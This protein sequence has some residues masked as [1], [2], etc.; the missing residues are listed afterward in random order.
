MKRRLA[1]PI[2]TML[3]ACLLGSSGLAHGGILPPV[4]PGNG[5]GGYTGPT[6]PGPPGGGSGSPGA[7]APPGPATGGPS[8]NPTG[9]QPPSTGGASRGPGS[10][11]TGG[12]DSQGLDSWE[13]WWHFNKDPY[14][15]L[16]RAVARTTFTSGGADVIPSSSTTAIPSR[17]LVRQRIVPA[18]AHLLESERANDITTGALVAL[19][20]IGEPADLP[21]ESSAIPRLV[22][23]LADA[24]Q[25][26]AE[27]AALAL[28]ISRSEAAIPPLTD[29]LAA[30]ARGAKLVG[31]K[32]VPARTRAFAAFG[33]GLAAERAGQNRTRQ[34]VA[35]AL[36]DALDDRRA[37]PDVQ[38]AAAIGLS[39]DPIDIEPIESTSA[40]WI[41]RQTVL[42]HLIRFYS[43]PRNHRL[44][45]AHAAT[46][47]ARLAEVAPAPLRTEVAE[48][49]LIAL[50]KEAKLENEIVLSCIQALGRLADAGSGAI[51]RKVRAALVHTLDDSDP[52]ARSFA[53]IALA[54]I[55]ARPGGGEEV[56]TGEPPGEQECRAA[57]LNEV[58]RGKSTSKPWAALALGILER[59]LMDRGAKPSDPARQVL[60]EWLAS[61]R[62][63]NE[64]GAGAI[65][66][67]LCR[68]TKAETMLRS[69]LAD[70]NED[71]GQGY[72]ALALGMLGSADAA[73]ALR[74]LVKGSSY[75]PALLEQAAEALALLGDKQTA[76]EIA[77]LLGEARGL[78]AQASLAAALGFIGDARSVDPL[79]ALIARKDLQASARGLAAAALGG[80]ADE[81]PLPWHSTISCG[82]NYRACTASLLAGDGTGLL[83]IL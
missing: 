42:R 81:S 64:V 5:G 7:S 19:A 35:R 1:R 51:D 68:E 23:A 76:P 32:E 50:R 80:V 74:D 54:E 44:V 47:L 78:A 4:K 70:T 39:L 79:L 60:R 83:E 38:V 14:L 46:A 8:N 2:A 75:R 52:Q 33:L 12:P 16:K 77:R 34:M 72:I 22:L 11:A 15:E 61:A 31:N 3:A 18:L 37:N 58:L 43:D 67:G 25:E 41:S 30:D 73:P 6:P 69:R 48:L 57:L 9:A 17:D 66:L 28:G 10:V 24:N 27:T 20:R 29:L 53:L 71:T 82:L 65:A 59:R 45:R 56:G 55:G 36:I 63:R 40:P 49:L 26:I 62:G 13:T 21:P